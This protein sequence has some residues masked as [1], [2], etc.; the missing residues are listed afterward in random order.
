M[1]GLI[2]EMKLA[3]FEHSSVVKIYAESQ[4]PK[5]NVYRKQ[6]LKQSVIYKQRK[7]VVDY[8]KFSTLKNNQ[9]MCL[10]RT[11]YTPTV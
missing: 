1:D 3:N 9:T 7:V 6:L 5:K 2:C 11:F 8:Y 4:S 10:I